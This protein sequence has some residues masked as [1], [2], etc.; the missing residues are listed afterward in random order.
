MSGRGPAPVLDLRT[1]SRG[2]WATYVYGAS[3]SALLRA[4]FAVARANDPAPYWVS[5]READEPVVPPGPLELGWIPPERLFIVSRAE[6]RPRTAAPPE[7][8]WKVVRS[9][10]PGSTIGDLTRFLQLPEPVQR[11]LG[12]FGGENARRVF[13]VANADRVREAY[14][15]SVEGVRPILDTMLKAGALP[16]FAATSPAG[17]GRFA[18]DFVLEVRVPDPEHWAEGT[19][20]CEKAPSK[21]GLRAGQGY[22]LRTIPALGRALAGQAGP[23]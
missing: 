4:T 10:E 22:P 7:S 20:F 17:P 21:S 9:D 6:A 5:I 13:V 11:L 16:V 2:A 23:Y 14:P 15:N 8:I 1:I 12:R 18:F 3:R 19:L